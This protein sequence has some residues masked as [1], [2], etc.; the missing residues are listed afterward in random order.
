ML[1]AS[2]L[3]KNFGSTRAVDDVSFQIKKGEIVGF[4][5]PNGAG[6]TT[7]LRLLTGFLSPDSGAISLNDVSVVTEPTLAQQHIGYLPENNPLY[8]ELLVSDFLALAGSLQQLDSEAYGQALDFVV[9]RCGIADVFYRPI[10]ELSKGYKQ[11]VG[12]AAALL[13]R[14]EII[15]MDEPTEGLDP[16]Q[17][18]EIR[19]LIKTL[20]K[21]QT[22]I[23]STHVMQ[24]AAAACNRLL[25]INKGRLIADGTADQ[26]SKSIGK[27][28]VIVV[29]IEGPWVEKELVTIKD[30]EV[31]DAAKK[32]GHFTA[33]LVVNKKTVE[34][35]PE[36]ARLAR[37]H[38][39][40]IWK[41]VE[42][43][44]KLEDIFQELTREV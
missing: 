39:W 17:R 6:K 26:L 44:N 34:I 18:G 4:L 15:I 40:I 35:Q 11:R 19:N 33:K 10:G 24:E 31:T 42:Q 28:Q 30:V 13:H 29:D 16:I 9:P 43:E 3:S 41:L 36:I 22:I 8:P 38:R 1:I 2:H 37:K 25:I 32:D 27:K 23:M 20:G 12:I 7:T 5:G 21:T 14:P